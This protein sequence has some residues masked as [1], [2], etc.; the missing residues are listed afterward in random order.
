[1]E[2]GDYLLVYLIDT[3]QLRNRLQFEDLRRTRIMTQ[4]AVQTYSLARQRPLHG[5]A[6]RQPSIRRQKARFPCPISGDQT[7]S[8][9][10]WLARQRSARSL[11]F[12]HNFVILESL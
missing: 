7:S 3:E 11:L 1:M 12:V 8:R 6:E 4:F 2:A 5:V 10:T 9:V